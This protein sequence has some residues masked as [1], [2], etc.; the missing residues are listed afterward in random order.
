[1]RAL[2]TVLLLAGCGGAP[3]TTDSAVGNCTLACP[4]CP[5][6]AQCLPG[7]NLSGCLAGCTTSTECRENEVC[8]IVDRYADGRAGSDLPVCVGHEVTTECHSPTFHCGGHTDAKCLDDT[9]L[10]T[11]FVW[12]HSFVCGYIVT[13]CAAGC[14][15]NRCN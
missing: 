6:A 8:A 1:M 5:S 14:T 9:R 7:Y 15:S 3:S 4:P 10:A 2:L 12:T 11:G 13:S